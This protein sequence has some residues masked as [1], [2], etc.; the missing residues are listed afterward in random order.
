MGFGMPSGASW[1]CS[2]RTLPGRLSNAPKTGLTWPL[3]NATPLLAL[4]L[5]LPLLTGCQTLKSPTASANGACCA[6]YQ[7]NRPMID[8]MCGSDTQ[9]AV[10]KLDMAMGAACE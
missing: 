2:S 8:L 1:R 7:A 4:W 5:L 9:R 6:T 10:L 3:L